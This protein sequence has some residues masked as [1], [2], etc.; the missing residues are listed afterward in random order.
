LHYRKVKSGKGIEIDPEAHRIA[1][2]SPPILLAES[3]GA[4]KLS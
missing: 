1:S 3:S 2:L 4:S